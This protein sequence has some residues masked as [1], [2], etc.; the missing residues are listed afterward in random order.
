RPRSP[1][2]ACP[3]T[4]HECPLQRTSAS[5]GLPPETKAARQPWRRTWRRGSRP[6]GRPVGVR[7]ISVADL[8]ATL[9]LDGARGLAPGLGRLRLGLLGRL[10]LGRGAGASL[11]PDARAGL[12][13]DAGPHAA[14]DRRA[15]GAAVIALLAHDDVHLA[16]D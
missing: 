3:L 16:I 10:D 1:A 13:A 4:Y 2:S 5:G 11:D 6:P 12:V 7:A 8:Q 9:D 14:P 15:G